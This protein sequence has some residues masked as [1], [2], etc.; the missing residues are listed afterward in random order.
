MTLAVAAM[1]ISLRVSAQ[2]PFFMDAATHPSRGVTT[3]R[4]LATY[5]E[6]RADDPFRVRLKAAHGLRSDWAVLGDW[7]WRDGADSGTEE[8]ML[9]LK[10]RIWRRDLGPVNTVRFSLL[11][12]AEHAWNRTDDGDRSWNPTVGLAGTAILGR[13]GLNLG[14]G[15]RRFTGS[16]R[17]DDGEVRA[18]AAYLYRL[19]PARYGPGTRASWYAVSEWNARFRGT[20][21]HDMRWVPGLLYEAWRWAA[22]LGAIVPLTHEADRLERLHWG[23]VAGVRTLF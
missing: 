1:A 5:E 3:L 15:Y 11:A 8:L 4:G 23:V 7:G 9:R 2:E 6:Q 19:H 16:G 10:A 13:H 12:G 20:S 21:E 18:D 17:S 14:G 22:E